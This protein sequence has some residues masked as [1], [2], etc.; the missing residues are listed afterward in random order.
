MGSGVNPAA[1]KTENGKNRISFSPVV[2]V[3]GLLSLTRAYNIALLA[4][5]QY[6]SCIFFFTEKAPDF[7]CVTD[8]HF[9]VLVVCTWMTVAGGYII[10][11]FYD[12]NKDFV[13]HPH[14]SSLDGIVSQAVTLRIYLALNFAAAALSLYVSLR[15]VVFFSGYAFILWFYSHK[16]KKIPFLSNLAQAVCA[17][18]PLFA[19]FFY[20]KIIDVEVLLPHGFFIFFTL[21][22][23]SLL[24][25]MN[26]QKGDAVFG[27]R[28]IP[29]VLGP[30]KA[31][32]TAIL[33][34]V[35]A[36]ICSAVVYSFEKGNAFAYYFIFAG[37]ALLSCIGITIAVKDYK[38]YYAAYTM[39]KA[40]ILIGLLWIPLRMWAL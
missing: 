5:A 12:K 28:T 26:N 31:E 40:L 27:Y 7:S 29:L 30:R 24:N 8:P 13:N 1:R 10:N 22:S 14:K 35:A 4:T 2:K 17:V 32:V 38:K 3:V 19:V 21:L 18:I 20:R 6:F 9:F 37:T 36:T 34:M 25:D 11:Y 23:L 15:S 16:L 33:S 39:I